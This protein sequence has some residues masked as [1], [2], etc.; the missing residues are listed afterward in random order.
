M[1]WPWSRRRS[2]VAE[3]LPPIQTDAPMYILKSGRKIRVDSPYLLPKD[4]EESNRLDL[5][6]YLLRYVLNSNYLAPLGQPHSILDVGCGTGRW[7]AEMARQFPN[8]NVVGVDIAP[9]PTDSV[10]VL[11]GKEQPPENFLFIEGDVTRGLALPD[12]SFDFVH[13]RLVVLALPQSAWLPVIHELCRVTRPGGWIELVDTAVTARSPHSAQWVIW[14]QMLA[15]ARG[16]DMTAGDQI[17]R[18]LQ[19]SGVRNVQQTAIE[20]PLGPWGGRIGNLM[21]VDALAGARAMEA[22]VV[23][24]AHLATHEQFQAAVEAMAD[25][26]RTLPSCTQPFYFA[27]GQK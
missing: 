13:M 15:R 9:P 4:L 20:I 16:I 27:Y 14:A 5:Q 26:Y 25:D 22:P 17:G 18:Y 7:G 3:T 1:P 21:M 10:S 11:Q 19:Q 12:N 6:H 23:D 2:S 24:L 8:A